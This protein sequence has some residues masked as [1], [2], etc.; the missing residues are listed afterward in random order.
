MLSEFDFIAKT[1]RPLA[2]K[3]RAARNL[4]DDAALLGAPPKGSLYVVSADSYSEDVH[5]LASDPPMTVGQKILRAALSDLAAMGAKPYAWL[6]A[7]AWGAGWSKEKRRALVRG[8]AKAQKHYG[9]S[10]IG[11]DMIAA[12]DAALFNV[13]VIGVAKEQALLTRDGMKKGDSLYVS[14]TLGDAALGLEG[15]LGKRKV[16]E[17]LKKRYRLPEPRISLGLGVGGLAHAAIDLSD[18]LMA[19]LEHMCKASGVGAEIHVETLPLSAA[20]KDAFRDEEALG[21]LALNAGDDYELLI[22]APPSKEAKILRAA[23]NSK[24]KLTRIGRVLSARQGIA[25]R[26][27]DGA[28]VLP[29][30]AGFTH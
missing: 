6:F 26:K 17:S 14:G 4:A 5:F 7:A 24:T 15:L 1:L 27:A 8:L 20:A 22:A 16:K 25:A 23:N 30:R 18:G 11:G 21:R 12:P 19:D 3:R 2:K 9:L 13:T 28:R 10:L 29:L